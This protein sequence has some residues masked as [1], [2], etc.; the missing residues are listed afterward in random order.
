MTESPSGVVRATRQ[1]AAPAHDVFVL[2][3]T[4]SR[5]L[6]FDG[7]GMLRGCDYEGAVTGVGDEFLMHM[8][9]EQ[10]GDYVM[11]NVIVEFDPD[12]RIAWAPV[13]HDIEDDDDWQ[14]RWVFELEPDGP[15][16]TSLTEIYDCSRAP[17]EARRIMRNGTVWLEGM[18][19]TIDRIDALLGG[20]AES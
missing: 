2:L 11:R 6:E 19:R 15:T 10:F 5:H 14:H 16:A 1:V 17:D 12:R 8:Y 3:A 20:G 13:R 18:Q 9:Y 4:P 7:S